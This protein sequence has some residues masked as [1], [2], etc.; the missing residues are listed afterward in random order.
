M[1]DRIGFPIKSR[2]TERSEPGSQ[3]SVSGK[4]SFS[5]DAKPKL[6]KQ[7][8]SVLR[9]CHYSFMMIS[10]RTFIVLVAIT[11]SA[12]LTAQTVELDFDVTD[13]NQ[14]GLYVW[15]HGIMGNFY[16]LIDGEI[17]PS[18]QYRQYPDHPREQVEHLL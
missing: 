16:S 10:C 8:I 5:T 17:L 12:S 15:N 13:E 14:L 7:A 18:C 9:S 1:L 3:R 2:F 4:N 6:L 11:I